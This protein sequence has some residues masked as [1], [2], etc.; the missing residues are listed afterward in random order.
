MFFSADLDAMDQ[1]SFAE[2]A[3]EIAVGVE[4]RKGAD[5]VLCQELD[6]LGHVCIGTYGHHVVNHYVD[7]AHLLLQKIFRKRV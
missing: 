3:D 2:H 7:C 1:V 6:R 5:I 4:N